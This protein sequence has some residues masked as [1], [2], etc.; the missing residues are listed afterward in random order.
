MS[1][2][3]AQ[4]WEVTVT[5]PAELEDSVY[6]HFEQLGAK[7]T[8]SQKAGSKAGQ[9]GVDANASANAPANAP[10]VAEHCTIA[11]YFL[12]TPLE[13]QA[14]LSDFEALKVSLRA[15]ASDTRDT[16]RQPASPLVTVS[17][18]L[19]AEEDWAKSWKTHWKA[20]EIGQKLLINPAWMKPPK[21][22]RTIL[23]LD[24]GSAF[25]TGAHA[26]TQLC[27]KAL[28]KQ[29]LQNA[30]IADIGCGSGI[31]SIA[32]L[33]Y[34][35]EQAYAV[36]VDP[37]A[38]QA[39][40]DNAE[41]NKIS[42]DQLEVQLGSLPEAITLAFGPVDG[43]LCNILAEIIVELIIPQLSKL[44]GPHTWGIFSGI[45]TAKA[46]WVEAHLVEHGWQVNEMTHQDE[47]CAIAIRRAS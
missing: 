38:V 27:L 32:A 18:R 16:E 21:T 14:Q 11:A 17:W 20:E 3:K 22:D 37:L 13:A 15:L 42:P 12:E 40:R 23:R 33:L 24:P 43:I 2:A 5:C 29:P 1:A 9:A 4:W 35:A 28:E 7:G 26:T 6:W 45:L 19:I 25:G 39:T 36:D 41:L 44:A 10:S 8:A 46:A 47:W 30:I 31:L 34:G